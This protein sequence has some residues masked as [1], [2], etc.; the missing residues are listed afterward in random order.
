MMI[1]DDEDETKKARTNENVESW[2]SCGQCMEMKTEEK[3]CVLPRVGMRKL[4]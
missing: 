3:M 1:Y 2:C 4:L